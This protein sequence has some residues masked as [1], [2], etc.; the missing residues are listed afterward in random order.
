MSDCC[1][2]CIPTPDSI[3]EDDERDVFEEIIDDTE[4]YCAIMRSILWN[5]Y[6]SRG[7]GSC[8]IDYWVKSMRRR[9]AMI[10]PTYLIKFKAYD[11]WGTAQSGNDPI[12]MS[13]GATQYQMRTENED[14]PDNPQGTTVYLSDRN[15]VNYDGKTF[16]GLSSETLARFMDAVPDLCQ[17]FA[18]EFRRLFYFGV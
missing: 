11:E 1:C 4:P 12:D 10:A 14:T 13:D 9:Y 8:N 7:I 16:S 5:N 18:D 2:R 6:G 3:L 17:Q 15:T